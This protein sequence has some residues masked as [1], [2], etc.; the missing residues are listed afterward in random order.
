MTRARLFTF[1]QRRSLRALARELDQAC[2]GL[3]VRLC[4][5]RAWSVRNL[6]L[7]LAALAPCGTAAVL[8]VGRT[9]DAA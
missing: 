6:A 4:P 2:P 8:E 3:G 9:G 5:V 1:R 7:S